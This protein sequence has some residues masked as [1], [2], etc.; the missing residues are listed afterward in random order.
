M[1]FLFVLKETEEN[2]SKVIDLEE[3]SLDPAEAKEQNHLPCV[4]AAEGPRVSQ[5]VVLHA[6]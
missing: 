4:H 6:R 1:F 5:E 2:D 3:K